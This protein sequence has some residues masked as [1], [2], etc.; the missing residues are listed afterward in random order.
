MSLPT[1]KTLRKLQEKLHAKAKAESSYRFYSLWDK[2]CDEETLAEAYRRC[3]KNGG[4]AGTDGE[5]FEDIEE[6]GPKRW[7]EN[8]AED[9]K[10]GS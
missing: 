10:A 2:V 1:S 4:A 7:L 5:R 6:Q 8:L 3:R 9:L